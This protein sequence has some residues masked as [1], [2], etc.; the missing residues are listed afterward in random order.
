MHVHVRDN[1]TIPAFFNLLQPSSTFF[2]LLR[3]SSAFSDLKTAF[4]DLPRLSTRLVLERR[5]YYYH[6][7]YYYYYYYYFFFLAAGSDPQNG[8]CV[9]SQILKIN[10]EATPG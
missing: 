1:M 3:L 8:S 10:A 4:S 9:K 7:Y 5:G 2:S 6:Y